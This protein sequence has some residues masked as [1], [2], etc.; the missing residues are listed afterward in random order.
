MKAFPACKASA[1]QESAIISLLAGALLLFS[2]FSCSD[3]DNRI[4]GLVSN[5]VLDWSDW[6]SMPG[7]R[8]SVFAETSLDERT[9]YE[10][11]AVHNQSG[12]EWQCK[13][14]RIIASSKNSTWAGYTNFVPAQG[15]TIPQGSYTLYY[16]DMADIECQSSFSV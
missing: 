2:L 7:A 12:L 10:I 13:N 16:Q 5:V 4:T 14:P 1:R 3:S 11:R 9:V 15:D 8:L 6:E